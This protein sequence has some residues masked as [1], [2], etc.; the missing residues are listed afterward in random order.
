MKPRSELLQ[1]EAAGCDPNSAPS[2]GTDRQISAEPDWTH[3][4]DGVK[5]LHRSSAE[6][7]EPDPTEKLHNFTVCVILSTRWRF[8]ETRVSFIDVFIT[9]VRLKPF[10][11]N[12][13]EPAGWQQNQVTGSAV[14]PC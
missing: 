13:T 5:L 1:N 6:A 7:E 12:K 10:G 11:G 14:P 2:A 4:T 8:P 9:I 3:S